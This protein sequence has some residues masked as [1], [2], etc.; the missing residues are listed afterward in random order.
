M[1]C[2]NDAVAAAT[3]VVVIQLVRL[4]LDLCLVHDNVESG[5]SH[6]YKHGHAISNVAC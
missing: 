4:N 6:C 2:Q 1:R 3:V 5:L